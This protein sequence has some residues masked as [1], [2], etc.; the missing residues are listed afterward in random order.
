MDSPALVV[1]GPLH[2]RLLACT[3]V[4]VTRGDAF[5]A[6]DL[7]LPGLE[8]ADFAV[9]TSSE[10]E[11]PFTAWKEPIK[12]TVIVSIPVYLKMMTGNFTCTSVVSGVDNCSDGTTINMIQR[13]ITAR[14]K[15]KLFYLAWPE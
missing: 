11:G 6:I 15:I 14:R 13:P 5:L 7:R 3:D 1:L 12:G 10:P 8:R 9:A 4:A 2:A